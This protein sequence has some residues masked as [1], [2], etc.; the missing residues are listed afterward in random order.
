MD[1][2]TRKDFIR[3]TSLGI[4][5]TL[6]PVQK[7]NAI[8]SLA[9]IKG[10]TT[11]DDF[12]TAFLLAKTAKQNFYNKNFV[13][14]ESQYLRCISLAPRAIRFYDGLDNVYCAQ[15]LPLLSVELFKNGMALNPGVIAFY[16]RAARSLMRLELGNK[17]LALDYQA[18]I[19]SPSLLQDAAKL[20]ERAISI[21]NT[22][23]YLSVGYE[24]V[25]AKI[26]IAPLIPGY[27]VN[28]VFKNLKNAN[29]NTYKAA[30]NQK[31]DEEINAL[32]KKIDT[33]Q[34][35]ELFKNKEIEER[36]INMLLQKKKYYDILQKRGTLTTVE[37][38]DNA[39]KLFEIDY[40]DPNSLRKLRLLYYSNNRFF[41]FIDVRKRFAAAS[42][43]FHGYLGVMDTMELS[44]KKQQAGTEVL[45]EALLIG[46][47][48]KENWSLSFQNETEVVIKIVK[49]LLLL[50]R[51]S[52]AQLMIEGLMMKVK[53]PTISVNNKL[54]L[55]YSK[56]FMEQNPAM[57]KNILLIGAKEVSEIE[58][59]EMESKDPNLGLVGQ[60]ADNKS[61]DKFKDNISLYYQLFFAHMALGDVTSATDILDR[62][63]VNNPLDSFVLTRA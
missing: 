18:K 7:I 8:S 35:R 26:A 28:R 24:K 56:I 17:L 57:S 12:Q 30:I 4:A 62:L 5:A 59:M 36:T 2:F 13:D 41:D 63:L 52:E 20:Y 47:D 38:F 14:A 49:I 29:R 42:G 23:K 45:D 9:K 27:K 25:L 53:T 33:K 54:I 39:V 55:F 40:K 31:T 10:K 21:D 44:Y 58:R 50:S 3:L 1:N 11:D 37:E 15:G 46:L 22:K 60:L 16:D 48:I 61:K 19:S 6:L 34:R 51:S 43:T 32:I